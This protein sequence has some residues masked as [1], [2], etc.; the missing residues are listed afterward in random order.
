MFLSSVTDCYAR[1]HP[2]K[3]RELTPNETKRGKNDGVYL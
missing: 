2:E 3:L 1:I